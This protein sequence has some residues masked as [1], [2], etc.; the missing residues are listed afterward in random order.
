LKSKK[1]C[2]VWNIAGGTGHT[3]CELDHFLRLLHTGAIERSRRYV[4]I[5]KPDGF[6]EVCMRGFGSS[7]YCAR[8]SYLL[9]ALC[10]PLAVA[11]EDV[12][13]DCGLSR[14]KW[15]LGR[16][17]IRSE[18]DPGQTY[19]YQMPKA[20][21][22]EQLRRYFHLRRQSLHIHPLRQ[23]A[24]DDRQLMAFLGNDSQPLALIQSKMDVK[25]ATAAPTDP[26]TYLDALIYLKEKGYRLV[27][28]GRE[29]M[30]G[31]FRELNMLNYAASTC[32]SFENDLLLFRRAAVAVL[33]GSGLAYVA[34]CL[35]VPYLYL[36]AWHLA[37]PQMSPLCVMVPTLVR[38]FSG[39]WLLFREQM[40]L[41]LD[42][43]DVGAEVFPV[44]AYVARNASSD[45][46]AT[47]LKE[48][49]NDGCA[50]T[51][52][53]EKFKQLD[54]QGPLEYAAARYSDYFLKKHAH[55]FDRTHC[56]A[57]LP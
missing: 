25:N 26:D 49:L 30:P 24:F 11:F 34:D 18:T 28:V 39:E 36:N 5:Q 29:E 14:L 40:D 56:R 37:R 7:F 43:E 42:L 1:V 50:F 17:R 48:L 22:Q 10:L 46:I 19:L 57:A 9:Y 31:C 33:S 13:V 12:T 52:L 45:E 41:Y 15:Q 8:A 23:G 53:Q 47:A 51:D 21:N 27:F 54:A 3:T 55:L 16:R 32:A 44:D 38:R 20:A 2:L 35:G 4:W 6:S